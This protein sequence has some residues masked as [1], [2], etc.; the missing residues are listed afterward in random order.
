MRIG[1]LTFH[2]ANNYGAVL[3][4]YGLQQT[5]RLLGHDCEII[6]YR[7]IEIERRVSYFSLRYNSVLRVLKRILVSR[8]NLK[9][10]TEHFQ[11]FRKKYLKVSSGRFTE[12]NIADSNYDLFVVGSDQVWNPFLT[13]G[14]DPI[15]WGKCAGS[16]PIITY[17][18]STNI[19]ILEKESKEEVGSL[20][21]NFREL[22][23]RE[24]RLKDWLWEHFH[25]SS[26]LVLDPTLLAG[27]EVCNQIIAPRMIKEPYLLVYSV[28]EAS[29]EFRKRVFDIANRRGLQVVVITISNI[30]TK[31]FWHKAQLIN[32]SIPQYLSLIKYADVVFNHSFHGTAFSLLFNRE[33]YSY[34]GNNIERVETVLRALN[35]ENRIIGEAEETITTTEIDYHRV[36][37]KLEEMR[38]ES[39]S[40]LSGAIERNNNHKDQMMIR[41]KKLSCKQLLCLALYYGFAQFLPESAKC[42]KLGGVIRRFLCR[43]IFKYSGKHINVE[44]RAF[45]GAGTEIEL[46]DHSGIGIHAHVPNGTRIGNNVMMGPYCHILAQ[47][48][49]FSRTDIPMI[50]Q[51]SRPKMPAVIGNDV[52]IGRN[53]LITPGR[54]IKDGTIVAGGCV[55]CKDFPEYSIVGGNPSR[56]IRSRK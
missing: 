24:K 5:I 7:N 2:N 45:F 34:R 35:L 55:L 32:P 47:N 3:Q 39:L 26:T 1:I 21:A 52:W 31:T 8:K 43:R 14:L 18:A 33:F 49:E 23:V 15:Y 19:N 51:G 40:Y 16:H 4:A 42:M 6:D 11:S 22:G 48:H 10:K 27:S 25:Q 53:V 30:Q 56:L 41:N 44:R 9:A 13:G 12:G 17:A 36:N 20:L 37:A 54:T 46:G 38:K 28:Q 50:Q 29:E